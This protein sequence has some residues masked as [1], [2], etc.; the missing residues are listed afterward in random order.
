MPERTLSVK[1]IPL[2]LSLHVAE[3]VG[4][5]GDLNCH[6]Q[7]STF[8]DLGLTGIK[9]P[10]AAMKLSIKILI[11][12]LHEFYLSRGCFMHMFLTQACFIFLSN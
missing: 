12:P 8:K 9:V 3:D 7:F 2:K 6:E 11:E 1:T 5:L 10:V 4:S